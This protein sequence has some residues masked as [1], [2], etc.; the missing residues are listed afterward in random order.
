MSDV[1]SRKVTCIGRPHLTL[2]SP[3]K[4]QLQRN[5]SLVTDAAS[6]RS[7][8]G[9]LTPRAG[10]SHPRKQRS[11]CNS[12]IARVAQRGPKKPVRAVAGR[13]KM[14]ALGRKRGRRIGAQ[15]W[16][17]CS[18]A[19]CFAVYFLFGLAVYQRRFFLA[20]FQDSVTRFALMRAARACV[21]VY[22]TECARRLHVSMKGR[23]SPWVNEVPS[24]KRV[25]GDWLDISQWTPLISAPSPILVGETLTEAHGLRCGPCQPGA[26]WQIHSVNR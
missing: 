15:L 18:P 4:T 1:R 22:V 7:P 19:F 11:A 26:E 8:L 23:R 17:W 13:K 24:A 14:G 5:P 21:C 12:S 2:C 6:E 16:R 10:A 9:A 20:G 3:R 25:G